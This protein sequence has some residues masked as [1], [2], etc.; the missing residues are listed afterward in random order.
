MK[1]V[2]LG[3]TISLTVL[4]LMIATTICLLSSCSSAQQPAAVRVGPADKRILILY[5]SRT[6]NTKAV[7]EFIHENVGGTLAPLEVETPYPE[8]YE[9]TVRHVARENES[10]YLPPIKTRIDNIEK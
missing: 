10:G 5:L 2:T 4:S 8:N 7:A 3:R 6:N 9:A 1:V